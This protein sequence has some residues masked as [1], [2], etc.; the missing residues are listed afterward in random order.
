MKMMKLIY[1]LYIAVGAATLY[2]LGAGLIVM[3]NGV[4]ALM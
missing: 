1:A 3:H 4:S 2:V